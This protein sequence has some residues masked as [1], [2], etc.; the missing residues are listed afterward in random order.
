MKLRLLLVA[1]LCIFAAN[2]AIALIGNIKVGG[3]QVPCAVAC[4]GSR[5]VINPNFAGD[6]FNNVFM[7]P[8]IENFENSAN[9][10][11]DRA[12]QQL[13][14][15][16]TKQKT[17]FLADIE[18][19]S[20]DQIASVVSQL[21]DLSNETITSLDEKLRA[22]LQEADR[23]LENRLGTLDALLSR[24]VNDVAYSFHRVAIFFIILLGLGIL[25]WRFYRHI[26]DHKLPARA[27]TSQFAWGFGGVVAFSLSAYG[28]T[29]ANQRVAQNRITSQYEENY[30]IAF[31]NLNLDHSV[32]YST[33]LL[34]LNRMSPGAQARAEK[35]VILRDLF[36]RPALYRTED[37][38]RELGR[39]LASAQRAFIQSGSAPDPDLTMVY[40][41][42]TW[43]RGPDRF[44]EYIASITLASALEDSSNDKSGN[45][46][47]MKPFAYYY[48]SSY[49]ENPLSDEVVVDLYNRYGTNEQ[50]FVSW[51]NADKSAPG[52]VSLIKKRYTIAEL[53]A[54]LGSNP[55]NIDAIA[56]RLPLYA[57]IRTNMEAVKTSAAVISRY[58]E[59]LRLT[60]QV[61]VAL[62]EAKPSLKAEI[63]STASEIVVNW[64]AYLNFL[65]NTEFADPYAK[66][67]SL[68][69]IWPI[70]TRALAASKM[71]DGVEF[72]PSGDPGAGA[73]VRW[74]N[75]VVRPNVRES[76]YKL[77]K[78]TTE[79]DFRLIDAQLDAVEKAT[80]AFFDARAKLETAD[81]GTDAAAKSAAGGV[82]R[83][84]AL[85]VAAKGTALGLFGCRQK[86]KPDW[87]CKAEDALPVSFAQ[88]IF[89][90]A[91]GVTPSIM[92]SGELFANLVKQRTTPAL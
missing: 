71:A 89:D 10:S 43:Q 81:K 82:L 45:L 57:Y 44:S 8:S 39:K 5:G 1:L 61:Q 26:F 12:M 11:T 47:I 59:L 14:A 23:L 79:T 13:D 65:I 64:D 55:V 21:S 19:L 85:D 88:L 9:R 7:G 74:L 31:S 72:W 87:D 42:L 68:R 27:F 78:I 18:K 54:I 32:Y 70:Y 69:N 24:Q 92:D 36:A 75:D 63:R 25:C 37:G 33:Q 20:K 90:A 58:S 51:K 67:N 38:A 91:K 35:A 83:T 41:F 52:Q 22:Q 2:A 30:Q 49:L 50:E 77:L 17:T 4:G 16:L 34:F 40:G 76:T 84:S 73:H 48:I 66:L 3:F 56:R 80:R 62:P 6:F 15:V 46:L 29:V 28:I 53:K 60:G 86:G